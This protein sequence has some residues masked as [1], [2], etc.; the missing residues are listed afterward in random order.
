[1]SLEQVLVDRLREAVWDPD[2]KST[3][4]RCVLVGPPDAVLEATFGILTAGGTSDWSVAS[5]VTL[6]VVLVG[7]DRRAEQLQGT[8]SARATWDYALNMRDTYPVSVVLASRSVWDTIPESISNAAVLIGEPTGLALRQE[9]WASVI[10][11]IV[12]LGSV[13]RGTVYSTLKWLAD[14]R[15]AP[16]LSTSDPHWEFA[17]AV[18]EGQSYAFAAG[19][20]FVPEGGS[21]DDYSTAIMAA[22]AALTRIADR[23]AE[24]GLEEAGRAF[25]DSAALIEPAS[26]R[27]A[28]AAAVAGMVSHIALTAGSGLGFR[29]APHSYYRPGAPSD[30]WWRSLRPTMLEQLVPRAPKPQTLGRLEA[31]VR[32]AIA[33]AGTRVWV[34]QRD[35]TV[36]AEVRGETGSTAPPAAQLRRGTGKTQVEIPFTVASDGASASAHDSPPSHRKPIA[37]RVVA[38]DLATTLKIVSLD[39]FGPGGFLQDETGGPAALPTPFSGGGYLQDL[40]ISMSGDRQLRLMSTTDATSVLVSREDE[41]PRT[42]PIV[43][44]RADIVIALSHQDTISIV[45]T[46]RAGQTVGAWNARAMIEGGS[47]K[48]PPS[49][50]E[51]LLR[52][53]SQRSTPPVAQAPLG[54]IR[55]LESR[56]L[57]LG[58]N[59]AGTIACWSEAV[60][61]DPGNFDSTGR[62]GDLRVPDEF[63]PRPA[64]QSAPEAFQVARAATLD[65]LRE[66]RQPV[67]EL[68]LG[69]GSLRRLVTDYAAAYLDWVEDDRDALWAETVSLFLQSPGQH[70]TISTEPVALLIPPTHPLKL[71]WQA[72]AQRVLRE[73]LEA[74]E[75]CPLASALDPGASPGAV[76]IGLRRADRRQQRIFV[77]APSGDPYWGLLVNARDI[78]NQ[79]LRIELHRV[80]GWLRLAPEN[81]AGGLSAQHTMRALDEMVAMTPT[82]SLLRAGIVSATNGAGPVA[83]AVLSWG[84]GRLTTTDEEEQAPTRAATSLK[85]LNVYDYRPRATNPSP[86]SLA[87]AGDRTG[88]RLLWM[89]GRAEP[90]AG[91][92]PDLTL[93]ED[94][95]LTNYELLSGEARSILGRGGLVR[96]NLRDDPGDATWVSES[97]TAVRPLP[98]DGE[99]ALSWTVAR[100]I[101]QME[102]PIAGGSP[103]QLRFEPN[104]QLLRT[105]V[106]KSLFVAASSTQLDPA[107]FV[108]GAHEGLL[109]DFDIP[110][111]SPDAAGYYLIAGPNDGLAEGVRRGIG[112]SPGTEIEPV[113]DEISRRGIPILR[114]IAAGGNQARG[115]LGMLLGSR[116]LQDAFRRSHGE[117]VLPAVQGDAITMLLPVDPY[118][119]VF[120]SARRELLR[121]SSDKR[122]DLLVFGVDAS[123]AEI[124][125]GIRAVEVKNR[126]GMAA[127]DLRDALTQAEN[128]A[129]L[130]QVMWHDPPR[131]ELWDQAARLF[132][133]RCLDHSFRLYADP[134][135]HGLEPDAWRQLHQ[136]TI[137]AILAADKL[138][139]VVSIN[140][141]R[142]VAFRDEAESVARDLDGDGDPDTLLIAESD[143]TAL[144]LGSGVTP[145]LR[146]LVRPLFARLPATARTARAPGNPTSS[147]DGGSSESGEPR[148]SDE[149][150]AHERVQVRPIAPQDASPGAFPEDEIAEVSGDEP[151]G[152]PQPESRGTRETPRVTL[153]A[154][155]MVEQAFAGFI[156]NDAA[157]RQVTRDLLAATLTDPPR[158][159]RNI[160][161]VGPPS[162]GKT[163]IARRIAHALGLPFLRLDG[164]SLQSRERLFALLDEQLEASGASTLDEGT[165]AGATVVRYPPFA[166]FVDEV[167]LVSRPAQE[168]LL[169]LL[170]PR[171]RQ[172]RIGNRVVRVP[173]AT[174]L[175]ATTRPQRIDQALKSRCVQID[176]ELYDADQIAQMVRNRVAEDHPEV[177]WGDEVFV[178]LANLSRLVPRAAFELAE[179]LW[180]EEAVSE[181]ERPS[182]EHLRAVQRGRNIDDRGL[183]PL[184]FR[185][186]DILERA[187]GSVGEESL[188]A[189]LG[190]DRDQL[191]DSV[192]PTLLRMNLVVRGRGGREIT[193]QGR[194]YVAEHRLGDGG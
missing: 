39:N 40:A 75:R 145:T 175:F 28:A 93:V 119:A 72:H 112:L 30:P 83:E 9:P 134:D 187:S 181:F 74:K 142:L 161:F 20:P 179:D 29:R 185:Y 188:S 152:L 85:Q 183:R 65:A 166:V 54:P 70:G 60:S 19:V 66:R 147:K 136:A 31:T 64:R 25:A 159:S 148:H 110:A 123:G 97:R 32:G 131:N 18:L 111:N 53:H 118:H 122:A 132:L 76:T 171:D 10:N 24:D 103:T 194:A 11:A 7:G 41:P 107:C 154:R 6:P 168:S 190:I 178:R 2:A 100:L 137:T 51:R 88:E 143:R 16:R 86:T 150:V 172:A 35:V 189:Q 42:V 1:M 4:A 15:R 13:N 160:L 45:L 94:I 14:E 27:P 167:H 156:G 81:V 77:A 43:D 57:T 101:A 151:A 71:A 164:P 37:Y 17:A 173:D 130:A 90:E 169:T 114:R 149:A 62:I 67:P 157:V 129:R 113:L 48:A 61:S 63:D 141:A 8:H 192:E 47:D 125:I 139:D 38:G 33:T 174:F 140:A 22:S 182:L 155:A 115:E 184:D 116:L 102:A 191:F 127:A 128:L 104:Q 82:R 56:L 79:E 138:S 89:R 96:V 144:L 98:T 165:D 186:L 135:V 95:E 108:R 80:L 50:W 52:A 46:D 87:G 126:P 73:A 92:R 23:I 176:L 133:A 170:E 49:E 3:T 158:L 26:E 91:F 5:D 193:P 36:D 177:N 109:W 55:E 180:K 12:R 124:K 105:W 34:V 153:E 99:D 59:S 120:D 163:E 21:A 58:D 68:D 146:D 117:I 84:I 69:G 121:D 44:G 78:S 106:S 162:V